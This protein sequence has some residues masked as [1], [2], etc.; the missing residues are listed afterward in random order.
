MLVQRHKYIPRQW[1]VYALAP[2]ERLP[3]EIITNSKSFIC[4]HSNSPRA[5]LIPEDPG[6]FYWDIEMAV[7]GLSGR[8]CVIGRLKESWKDHA[9]GKLVIMISRGGNARCAVEV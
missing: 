9:A 5:K 4:C 2:Q 7:A 3:A 8:T 6:N 1:K